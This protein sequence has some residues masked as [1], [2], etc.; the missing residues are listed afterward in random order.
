[1]AYVCLIPSLARD[2]AFSATYE[3]KISPLRLEMTTATQSPTGG[4]QGKG[5]G[6]SQYNRE[7]FYAD[8]CG[9]AKV[10]SFEESE[11]F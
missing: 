6:L 1:L 10:R 5:V 2:L 11:K 4:E 7:G 8:L 3:G 9:L